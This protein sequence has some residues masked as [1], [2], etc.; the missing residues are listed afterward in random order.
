MKPHSSL[1]E[2]PLSWEFWSI[3]PIPFIYSTARTYVLVETLVEL[4][5]LPWTTYL[6]VDWLQFFPHI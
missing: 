5:S 4:R 6:I 2:L 1:R 3:F